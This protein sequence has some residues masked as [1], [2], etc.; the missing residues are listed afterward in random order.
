MYSEKL[1]AILMEFAEKW[2]RKATTA[3]EAAALVTVAMARV[4]GCCRDAACRWANR[5]GVERMGGLKKYYAGDVAK[6]IVN[7]GTSKKM[8]RRG[9]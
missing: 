8:E 3:A 2:A 1:E 4:L 6:A 7:G 9:T 5:N